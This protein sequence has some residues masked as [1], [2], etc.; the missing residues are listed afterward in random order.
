MA[1]AVRKF[2]AAAVFALATGVANA[3]VPPSAE[4]ASA[5][6]APDM[7]IERDI[8]YGSDAAQRLD[9]YRPAAAVKAPILMMVH[10]GGWWRGDK[11]NAAVVENK[12]SHWIPKGFVFVSVNYRL[13]PGA[14]PIGQ[15][16]DVAKALAF[17]QA[18]AAQWGGDPEQVVLMGHSAGAHLVALLAAAPGIAESAG[19]KAWL[20]TIALDSAAYD[21]VEVM[22]R[23]HFDLYDRAFGSDRELWRAASPALRLA[24]APAPMLLVCS[25]RRADA[26]PPAKAF[27]G[28]V[29]ALGGRATVL[30]VDMTHG[31]INRLLGTGGAYTAAI[32]AFLSSIGLK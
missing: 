6:S 21:V 10:G 16:N 5:T 13:V 24:R 9:L 27:A 15:A 11:G 3:Q 4:G 8:A 23:R 20:G 17:V 22:E 14:D 32:D 31:D 25:T 12:L 19:A 28:K 2:L 26:C 29:S 18:H 7:R 30:P 1:G